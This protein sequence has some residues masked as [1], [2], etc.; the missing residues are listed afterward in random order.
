MGM[1]RPPFLVTLRVFQSIFATGEACQRYLTECRWPDGFICRRCG[2]VASYEMMK[3]RRWQCTRC[4]YQVSLTARTILNNTKTP[5]TV[6]FW[7][8]YLND[9]G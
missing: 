7:A 2:N 3:L 6:W 4:R 1:A 8:A 9:G 5:L